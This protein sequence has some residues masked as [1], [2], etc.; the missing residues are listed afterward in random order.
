MSHLLSA[1]NQSTEG[2]LDERASSG[3]SAFHEGISARR[4][5]LVHDYLTQFGGAER[6]LQSLHQLFPEAPVYSSLVDLDALPATFSAWDLHQTRLAKLPWASKLHR[7]FLPFYPAAF[8]ELGDAL[9]E[10]DVV[11]ADSSA[12]AHHVAV[13][14][15]TALICYC[16][17][18][19]RF[20]YG[21]QHYLRPAS[22]PPGLRQLSSVAFA[23]LRR[24][25][26]LAARRV[27]RY[28]ANSRNVALRIERAYGRRAAVVYPPVDVAPF[29]AGAPVP[30]PEPW[31]LVVSRLVPHK[32]VDLA[33][34]ACTRYGIPLK[35][36]GGGRSAER[37]QRRA[38][39][40]VEFLGQLSDDDV[41]DHL[42][43]CR[44]LIL[45]G[46]EDFGMTAIEAQAAGRPVIAFAAGGALESILPGETGMFFHAPTVE[47]LM[48]A[49][50]RFE[51]RRWEPVTAQANARRF[52]VARF[53]AE[54]LEEIEAGIAARSRKRS[55]HA[56]PAPI[57][58]RVSTMNGAPRGASA[59]G[60]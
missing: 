5:A 54:I 52:G 59:S 42:K 11:V 12:W 50:D 8:R 1:D 44:A 36:I 37:L 48:E 22:L 39:P 30:Y 13:S 49:I 15:Q 56:S 28:I 29:L 2:A 53:H 31:Y 10:A 20:L 55:Y 35:V 38:G 7:A 51:R 58:P 14:D 6:V 43:R 25:D 45:P 16:H 46:L 27:D 24:Q 33:V 9:R 18:P 26:H 47:S 23:G 34:D 17:S 32:R 40:T 4:V 19:A 21:D 41:V 60:G 57:D 3:L